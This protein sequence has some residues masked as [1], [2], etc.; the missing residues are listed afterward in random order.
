[1]ERLTIGDLISGRPK[2]WYVLIYFEFGR[3]TKYV[4]T[5]DR[6]WLTGAV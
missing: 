3:T 2:S 5:F 1:M 4:V 6:R